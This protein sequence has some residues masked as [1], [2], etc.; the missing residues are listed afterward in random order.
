MNM[1]IFSL[2]T[3]ITGDNM[4]KFKHQYVPSLVA[5]G[6]HSKFIMPVAKELCEGEGLDIG[7]NRTEWAFPGAIPIDQIFDDPYDA[8]NLPEGKYDFIFSSHCLEH[9]PDYD[10][11]IAHWTERLKEGGRLF[12]YLPHPDCLYWQPNEMPTKRHIH[13][14]T[15]LVIREL[16]E[17]HG[18]YH[19]LYSERDLAYS[20][21]VTGIKS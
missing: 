9:L 17:H 5:K 6:H 10:A 13:T 4:I 8:Y 14:F 15:P 19:I 1:T 12:L 16:L 2:K 20:F 11:A 18:Y 7:C 21:A 3:N